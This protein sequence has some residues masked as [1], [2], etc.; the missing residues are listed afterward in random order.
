MHLVIN[1][2]EQLITV[3]FKKENAM[4]QKQNNGIISGKF[5]NGKF[6]MHVQDRIFINSAVN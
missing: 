1:H 3:Y 2:N 5:A 6:S 4:K